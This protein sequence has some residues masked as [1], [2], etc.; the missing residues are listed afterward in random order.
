VTENNEVYRCRVCDN[1][2]EV[3]K[4]GEGELVCCKAPMELLKPKTEGTGQEKH[5][6]VS[7]ETEV[8]FKVMV[9]EIPHP[10][11][12]NH[13]IEWIEIIADDRI[14]LQN[15]KPEET[16][17]AEFFLDPKSVEQITVRSYCN[18]HGLWKS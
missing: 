3:L 1:V 16:P 18:V 17:Q 9:G 15:L 13:F 7:E 5:V 10:M 6:P 2:I 12:E 14:H 4:R 11:E 8:G